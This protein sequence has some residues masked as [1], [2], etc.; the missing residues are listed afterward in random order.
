MNP[1]QYHLTQLLI[2]GI[3][4]APSIILLDVSDN[5]DTPTTSKNLITAMRVVAVIWGLLSFWAAHQ[6][7][8]KMAFAK[9][10]LLEAV[11]DTVREARLYLAFLPLVGRFFRPRDKSENERGGIKF[12][13]K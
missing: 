9:M 4:A 8:S 11:I 3:Y 7:A 10:T 13:R 2:F 1:I 5:L 12:D 6:T